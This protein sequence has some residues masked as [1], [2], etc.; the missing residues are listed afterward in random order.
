MFY[1]ATVNSYN[2]RD[3]V[4]QVRQY[5][6]PEGSG[7][8]QDTT[9]TYDG[10]GRLKTKHTPEQQVDP[11]NSSSTDH[12]T[13]DY[14]SDDTI[15]KITDAR[16]ASQTLSYNS[17]HLV[18]GITYAAPSG[19]NITAAAAVTLAYDPAGNRTSMTDGFGSVSYNYDEL[20]RLT[21][22]TR[23]FSVGSY[24]INYAYNLAA[25]SQASQTRLAP[26]SPISAMLRDG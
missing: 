20:S 7:T 17:R 10:Y 21:G 2:A 13:W 16:G 1:S 23:G 26:A 24:T 11:S 12:T 25:S 8:F 3:Q 6:G 15:Q 14:N 18:T 4:T 19:V 9:M 22:E 5:A